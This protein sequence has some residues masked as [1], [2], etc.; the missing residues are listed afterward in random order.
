MATV[1]FSNI[2]LPTGNDFLAIGKVNTVKAL[3]NVF[4]FKVFP[5]YSIPMITA[6]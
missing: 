5:H 1:S 6:Q 4:Q 3:I 2:K